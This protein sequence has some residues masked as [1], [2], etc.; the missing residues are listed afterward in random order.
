M[1]VKLEENYLLLLFLFLLKIALINPITINKPRNLNNFNS[2]IHLV[3]QGNGM[4]QIL[5]NLFNNEPYEVLVNEVKYDS[6][7]KRC[8]LKRHQNKITLIFKSQI[9]SCSLMF[10]H[11]NNIL[12]IDLSKFDFSKVKSMKMMF[13]GCSNLEKVKL[14]NKIISSVENMD[15]LFKGCVK[16]TSVDLSNFDTS[17]VTNMKKMFY[18]CISLKYL[19]LYSFEIKREVNIKNIF[20]HISSDTKYCIKNEE[21][22]KYL[23]GNNLN[24][25]C[26]FFLIR[27]KRKVGLGD[28]I[29]DLIDDAIDFFCGLVKYKYN[30]ECVSECPH[31]TESN[32]KRECNIK[33]NCY[34]DTNTNELKECFHKCKS[35]SRGGNE[36]SHNCNQCVDGYRFLNELNN[37]NCYENCNN[38]Y[39]YYFDPNNIYH[40]T[41][42]Q[43]CPNN[44]KLI[45]NKRKCV[46]DCRN[47]NIYKYEYQN[48][49]YENCPSGAYKKGE[50]DDHICYNESPVGYYLDSISKTF[51]K[52][53]ETCK[54]CNKGG[55]RSNN[56][57]SECKS[58]LEFYT[59]LNNISNCYEDCNLYHYFDDS[60]EFHCNQ[61]CPQSYN[62]LII[63]KKEMY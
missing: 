37:N 33:S 6:C 55:D 21:T 26:S 46:D 39:Y 50:N 1:E 17:K 16:L 42:T 5:S 44:Y 14:G 41:Q 48:K 18:G 4:Q 15:S 45:L 53:Y 34:K 63:E 47:E 32:D 3:I 25:D 23:L 36:V 22:K 12:E 27:K 30:D 59:N 11:L 62:K 56:N 28:L 9:E 54:K 35:C 51:K 29:G 13:N 40:C 7:K 52:C 57:C 58:G 8:Y 60:N 38:N 43:L 2:E 49:C 20:T 19:N 24:S 10:D 61:I 31:C